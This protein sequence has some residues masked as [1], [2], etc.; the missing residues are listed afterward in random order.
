MVIPPAATASPL[1]GTFQTSLR[2]R[3]WARLSSVL[4]RTPAAVN[5]AATARV[6]SSAGPASSPSTIE[7]G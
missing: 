5:K 2:H 4:Q 1:K 7:P 6:R 3:A